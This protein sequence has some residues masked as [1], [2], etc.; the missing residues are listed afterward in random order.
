MT[1]TPKPTAAQPAAAQSMKPEDTRRARENDLS[2]E[3]F[4]EPEPSPMLS[5]E[6]IEAADDEV[7][8]QVEVPE[9]GG[10]VFVRNPTAREKN[11]FEQ[12]GLVRKRNNNREANLHDLKERLVINF[13]CYDDRQPFFC[14]SEPRPVPMDHARKPLA[15]L[16][17]KNSAAVERIADVALRLGGWTE[18]D[19]EEM[20]GN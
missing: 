16:R 5:P 15:M 20:V 6:A 12:Q 18:D 7:T 3:D 2:A 1:D 10:H 4:D 8:R 11:L 14:P 9:W 19:V 17:G 13:T